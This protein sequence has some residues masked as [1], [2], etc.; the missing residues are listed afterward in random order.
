[1]SKQYLF[2]LY[3]LTAIIFSSP[4]LADDIYLTD[5]PLPPDQPLN[6][7]AQQPVPSVTLRPATAPDV[8]ERVYGDIPAR[9]HEDVA[10]SGTVNPKPT[11]KK[12][13][14]KGRYAD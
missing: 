6:A 3:T 12:P 5:S 7:N 14:P 9:Q 2:T 8:E 4:A 11:T 13:A 10:D 1:M